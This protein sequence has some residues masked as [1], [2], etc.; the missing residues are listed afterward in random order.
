MRFDYEQIDCSTEEKPTRLDRWEG[1]L[2]KHIWISVALVVV[3]VLGLVNQWFW[4]IGLG[5]M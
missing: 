4:L 2:M 3:L 1:W 5:G